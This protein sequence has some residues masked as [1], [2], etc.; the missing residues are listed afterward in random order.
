VR[1]NGR[2]I[3]EA[4]LNGLM[5]AD[6]GVPVGLVTGDDVICGA[7]EK[8]FPGVVTVPVK[9]ALGRTAARS[10]HPEEARKAICLGATRAVAGARSGAIRPVP[11][12]EELVIEA[13]LRVSGAAEMAELVPGAE[14]IG[15]SSVRLRAA[16]P[17]EAM[18]VLNVWSMLASYHQNR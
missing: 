3:S 8:V 5:A 15:A 9:T 16:S 18:D 12:P 11:V 4:E 2:S 10:K 17:R 7:V 6:L 14:R 1:L 13:E